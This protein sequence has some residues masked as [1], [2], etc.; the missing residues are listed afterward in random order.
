M[1]PFRESNPDS[2]ISSLM[3][4]LM[5]KYQQTLMLLVT[6]IVIICFAWLY[7]DTRFTSHRDGDSVGEIYGTKLPLAQFQREA[8]K[9]DLCRALGLMELWLTRIGREARTESDAKESFV[10]NGLVLRHEAE[11]LG[12]TATEDEVVDAV[13]KLPAFQTNGAYDSSKYNTFVQNIA[14]AGFTADVIEELV[15]E[16][17]Y[18]EKL[19]ALVGTTVAASP[20]EVRSNFERR[21]QKSEVSVVRFNRDEFAKAVTISDADLKK[22]FEERKETLKSDEQRKVKVVGFTLEKADK[23]MVGKERTAELVKLADRAQEFTVA[24]TDKDAK[25]EDVAKKMGVEVKTTSD[26][27]A[28]APPAEVGMAPEASEKIFALTKEQPNSDVITT[29]NGYYVAQLVS[30]TPAQPLTFEQA[31]PQLEAELRDDRTREAMDLKVAEIRNKLVAATNAGKSFE[32]A[33]AEAGVKAEKIPAF[34]LMEPPKPDVAD[35][36]LIA[37][38]ASDLVE[39]QLSDATPSSTGVILIHVDKRLP[40]DEQKFAEEKSSLAANVARAKR[41]GAFE[42]WLKERRTIARPPTAR[43]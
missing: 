35:G 31:K 5:R 25:F 38:R 7:N 6:I 39:G 22:V 23:P 24:M 33:A 29:E 19:K 27:P 21:T 4:N 16:N 12:I 26:F 20:S 13:Q 43:G 11:A 17:L 15:R 34:S 32:A 9:F 14:S 3:V 2:F 41:E 28:S 37:G 8:R 18:L 30:I 1:T 42:L 36:R 40:I 10:W